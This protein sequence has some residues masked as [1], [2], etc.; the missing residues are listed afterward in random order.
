VV[1]SVRWTAEYILLHRL[2]LFGWKPILVLHMQRSRIRLFTFILEK[3]FFYPWSTNQ[4]ICSL[5]VIEKYRYSWV[6]I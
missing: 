3:G 4:C 5:N 6:F 2:I 1:G